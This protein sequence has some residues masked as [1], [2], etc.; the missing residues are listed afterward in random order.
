[1]LQFCDIDS[2]IL[3][4]MVDD[5][6]AKTGFFT[7]GSHLKIV[8]SIMNQDG[9]YPDYV[10]VF[11]WTFIDEIVARNTDYLEGGGKFIVPLPEVQILD[12][13]NITSKAG[14]VL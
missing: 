12:K 13:S 6:P 4:Y 8:S 11:A 9:T 3:E 2:T 5:A 1:V 10:V 14:D 7:P